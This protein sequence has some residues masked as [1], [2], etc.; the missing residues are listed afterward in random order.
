MTCVE[1]VPYK[2]A[3]FHFG[4]PYYEIQEK[5]EGGGYFSCQNV[6][7]SK[8]TEEKQRKCLFIHHF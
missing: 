6:L 4:L 8:D 5:K 2:T 3:N 1:N 7:Y